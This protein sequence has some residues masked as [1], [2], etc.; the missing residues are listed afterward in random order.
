M[1]K[2]SEK[3]KL[4]LN[5]LRENSRLNI[6]KLSR[7]INCPRSTVIDR[8]ACLENKQIIKRYCCLVDFNKLGYPMYVKCLFKV[9]VGSKEDFKNE[10]ISHKNSNNVTQLGNEYDFLV[11]FAFKSIEELNTC[12]ENLEQKYNLKEYRLFYATSDI[13]REQEPIENSAVNL[14]KYF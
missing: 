13:K 14:A 1:L 6:S 7:E 3:E 9:P 8:I 5:K 2:L 12:L 4:I 11:S 10:V